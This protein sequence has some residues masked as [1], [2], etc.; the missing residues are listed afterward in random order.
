MNNKARISEVLRRNAGATGLVA[1]SDK[2]IFLPPITALI[3][4]S[5]PLYTLLYIRSHHPYRRDHPP[6]LSA[7]LHFVILSK[8]Q[9]NHSTEAFVGAKDGDDNLAGIL[10]R[11]AKYIFTP[12]PIVSFSYA[13]HAEQ[14]VAH[15]VLTGENTP[16]YNSSKMNGSALLP[17]SKRPYFFI[18]IPFSL[19]RESKQYC[20][21]PQTILF[22]EPNTSV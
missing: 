14:L 5:L 22:E 11:F 9:M 13:L 18:A 12:N 16:H 8:C 20:F 21:T 17:E 10:G 2:T 1:R 6:T 4:H 19:H 3:P 15:R 7:T